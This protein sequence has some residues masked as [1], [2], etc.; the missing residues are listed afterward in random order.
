[1]KKVFE[2]KYIIISLLC[3]I[4]GIILLVCA[5]VFD[6]KEDKFDNTL[7]AIEN[8]FF[9][10]PNDKYVNMNDMSDYCKVSLIYG[11]KLLKSDI[12]LDK[13][14]Y[15]VDIKNGVLKAY[16]KDNVIKSLKNILGDNASINFDVDEDGEY[17][18]LYEDGCKLANKSIKTLS[19][20]QSSES[21][22]SIDDEI[23]NK[24]NIKLFVK[25]GEPETNDDEIVIHAQAL[26]AV[27]NG[28]GKYDIYADRELSHLAGTVNKGDLKYVVKEF[29]YK[30]LDYI[31]NFKLVNG[32][33]IWTNFEV[34]DRLYNDDFIV[35]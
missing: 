33:Y 15:D 3:I 21:L 2:K 5:F 22:F 28:E 20:S 24:N 17:S 14:N 25:W 31:F 32:N 16:S 10:L 6:T 23:D 30:S 35:D 8:V 27:K 4:F 9:F 18:F 19:Y 12:V 7:D 1:M 26:V 34:I 29:Y 11:S 13:K